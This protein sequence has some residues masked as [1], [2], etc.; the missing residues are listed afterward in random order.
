MRLSLLSPHEQGFGFAQQSWGING[1][2][3][4][5]QEGRGTG[6]DEARREEIREFLTERFVR[7][8]DEDVKVRERIVSVCC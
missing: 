1:M 7:P 6:V 2:G 8:A 4:M 3:G 5:N